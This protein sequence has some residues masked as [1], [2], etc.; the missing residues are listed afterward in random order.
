[1]SRIG[2]VIERKLAVLLTFSL[3]PALLEPE[4]VTAAQATAAGKAKLTASDGC[5]SRPFR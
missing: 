1:M 5:A 2:L 4:P 3:P